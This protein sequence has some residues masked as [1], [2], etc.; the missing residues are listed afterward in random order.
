LTPD[1]IKLENSSKESESITPSTGRKLDRIIIP[2]IATALGVKHILEGSVRRSSDRLRVTAQLIRTE[3]GFHL[4]PQSYDRD[5]A[6]LIDIQE[7]VFSAPAMAKAE[8]ASS[9]RI[10]SVISGR[11]LDGSACKLGR[12][13]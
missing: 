2:T 13:N 12:S 4:W 5:L 1:S 11:W 8:E 3:D 6:D 7:N 9:L 10:I